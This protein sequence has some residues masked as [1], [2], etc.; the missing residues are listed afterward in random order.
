MDEEF[1]SQ[2]LQFYTSPDR[3]YPEYIYD[4]PMD[5]RMDQKSKFRQQVKPYHVEDGVVKHG[6]NEVLTKNRVED[7]LR[8]FHDSPVSGGHFGRDKTLSKLA[9]RYYWK[10]I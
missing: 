3:K 10:G 6:K 2:I 4:V 7:I 5:K 8:A 9:E 1:Y